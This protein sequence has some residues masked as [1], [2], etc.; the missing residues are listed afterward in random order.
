MPEPTSTTAA[1]ATTTAAG[2]TVPMITAFG[3]PLGLRTDVL[4]AGLFG[5][6]VAILVLN[7]VPGTGDTWQE[8]VRTTFKRVG[9][10][11]ASS[12][13][14][15][16]LTPLGMLIVKLPDPVLLGVAFGVGVSA[17]RILL[18]IIAWVD[19]MTAKA[20]GNPQS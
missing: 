8:L 13:S 15:G 16:Y 10:A 17:Q 20:K 18:L 11:I 4:I 19:R 7:S 2:L 1:L 9:V 5:S 3:I 12:V 6:L 14:S